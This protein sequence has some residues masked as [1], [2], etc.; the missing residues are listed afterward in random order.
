M[1]AA[2]VLTNT[3]QNNSIV[4]SI[5]G[6]DFIYGEANN[7]AKYDTE[8]MFLGTLQSF[9]KF[10][11]NNISLQERRQLTV[12]ASKGRLDYKTS[13]V[14]REQEEGMLN[15]LELPVSSNYSAKLP[16]GK[17]NLLPNLFPLTTKTGVNRRNKVG[18]I[19]TSLVD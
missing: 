13:T 12:A 5:A 11:R 10:Y 2:Y 17:L 18:C 9:V 15:I 7:A 3:E 16:T 19:A 6:H 1:M 14:I 4:K 8:C